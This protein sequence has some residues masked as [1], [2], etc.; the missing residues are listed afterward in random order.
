MT[1]KP[2]LLPSN[3]TPLERALEQS[4]ARLGDVPIPIKELWNPATC[5]IEFLPWLAWALSADRWE[6]HWSEDQK[7]AA[8]A[9]AIQLQR[10]KGTPASLDLVLASFDA[11]LTMTEWF[12]LSPPGPAHTFTITL[13]LLAA[14]GTT[15]GFRTSAEFT[16]AIIRDV[17]RTKPARSHFRLLQSLEASGTVNVV[18]AGR[19]AGF[20]R[21]DCL[22]DTDAEPIWNTYLTTED[23][24]PLELEGG[25]FVEIDADGEALYPIA[26]RIYVSSVNANGIPVGDDTAGD[27]SRENPYLT[28]DKGY[29]VATAGKVV[30]LNGTAAAPADYR[31]AG[32]INSTKAI[33][34]DA[35]VPYGAKISATTTT[36]RVI[37]WNLSGGATGALGKVIV[38]GRRLN[39]VCL[40]LSSSP[41]V[42]Q[43]IVCNGTKFV[44]FLNYG[45]SSSAGADVRG[46]VTLNGC[47]WTNSGTCRAANYHPRLVEGGFAM[48][49]GTITLDK[50]TNA[51]VGSVA[52]VNAA[53]VGVTCSI[54]GV[55]A[56]LTTDATF[57]GA[58]AVGIWITNVDRAKVSGNTVSI[59]RA[60]GPAKLLI[61]QPTADALALQ[62]GTFLIE[63]NDFY[64]D[65]TGGGIIWCGY[66]GTGAGAELTYADGKM[67]GGAIR[68]NLVHA[69]DAAKAG[70]IHAIFNSCLANTVVE[71][72]R[73][74]NAG[75]GAVDKGGDGAIWRANIIEKCASSYILAKGTFNA[76]FLHNTIIFDTANNGGGMDIQANPTSGSNSFNIVYRG[77]LFVNKGTNS[78]NMVN[79]E[80]DQVY[81]GAFNDYW[82]TDGNMAHA[83]FFVDGAYLA[84]FAAYKAAK[85][86]T[87]YSL[88]PSFVDLAA[89]DY[90]LAPASAVKGLDPY[91][92]QV[93]IDYAGA[94]FAS[95]SAIGAFSGNAA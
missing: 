46:K 74:T 79:V 77:N 13:P 10:T 2:T 54:V 45:T 76:K 43:K 90:S 21:L 5:P 59:T 80:A 42:A 39:T 27:G 57:V 32:I 1:T 78:P 71:R 83:D 20:T 58:Y 51:V 86:T 69:S 4:S 49:G 60:D 95:P 16:E 22:A 62:T 26:N 88:D 72:N 17:I 19:T 48:N 7:R 47:I 12:E 23:G 50:L 25:G 56:T 66:D 24:E 53:A 18:A 84:D 28:I 14:D 3:A 81:W 75:I 52:L 41:T 85:E 93:L 15:G 63:A 40:E 73:I 38:D 70:A 68:R 94:A 34:F 89:G 87:A 65:S 35:V 82:V 9:Q 11:L 36:S 6:T 30:L 29:T 33:T 61:L 44:D 64:V 55:T 92:P 8:V 37:L 67:D 31:A 91:D